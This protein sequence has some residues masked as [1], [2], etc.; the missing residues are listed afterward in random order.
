MLSLHFKISIVVAPQKTKLQKKGFNG[1]SFRL[2]SNRA[3]DYCVSK[4]N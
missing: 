3:S 4:L 2:E 1:D